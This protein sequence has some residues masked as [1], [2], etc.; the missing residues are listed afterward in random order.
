MLIHGCLLRG[1]VGRWIGVSDEEWALI[2]PLLLPEYGTSNGVYWRYR[3]WA[4]TCVFDAMLDTFPI[5]RDHR[6]DGCT[7]P[8][9]YRSVRTRAADDPCPQF[10]CRADRQTYRL[11]QDQSRYGSFSPLNHPTVGSEDA[12]C[13]FG[14]A[15]AFGC[16][17][18]FLRASSILIV[19]SK[20]RPAEPW[21][22][23]FIVAVIAWAAPIEI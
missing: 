11:N 4:A 23:H 19:S 6:C 16:A 22:T 5:A 20:L 10:R 9:G 12:T 7:R 13:S 1:G 14:R 8:A 15:I 17:A 18:T 21:R 3:R 2:G